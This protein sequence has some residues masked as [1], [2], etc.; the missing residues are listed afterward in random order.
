MKKLL[1]T[2]MLTGV[3]ALGFAQKQTMTYFYPTQMIY[4][5]L[6]PAQV[7]QMKSEN[8]AGLLQLN[9]QLV[10]SAVVIAKPLDGE[11]KQ[12]GNLDKY[13]PEGVSYDEEEIIRN[14][15]LNPF[16]WK[17]PQDKTQWCV[18]RMHR[19]GYY[20]AVPPETVFNE[21]M[22]AFLKSYGF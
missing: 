3:L 4:E 1:L 10:N 15:A 11:V 6:T 12:M 16:K 20:V 13:V 5:Q 19:S 18:Y 2:M 14:G 7:E 17:L 22:Q 8:P 21:R 9:Y